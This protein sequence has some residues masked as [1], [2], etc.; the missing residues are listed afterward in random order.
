[1]RFTTFPTLLLLAGTWGCSHTM[2]DVNPVRPADLHA[3]GAPSLPMIVEFQPGD[4]IPL[5]LYV[6]GDLMELEPGAVA[7][8]V[9]VKK[10]FFVLLQDDAPP[11]LSVDGKTLGEV[12]GSV[13]VGLGVK[14]DQGVRATF[15]LTTRTDER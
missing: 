7:P 10:R 1:M 14:A 12:H 3:D 6:N 4:R 15:G 5:D 2:P 13:S 9:V 11:R 8:T